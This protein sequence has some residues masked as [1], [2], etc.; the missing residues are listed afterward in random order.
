M[1][2]KSIGFIGGGRVVKIILN[3]LNRKN[4]L[5]E[6]IIV[7]DVNEDALNNL[8]KD[9]PTIRITTI[10]SEPASCDYVFV[11]LHPPV[12]AQVLEE[13]KTSFNKEAIL[14]SLAPK[15]SIE[16]ISSLLGGFNKIVRMIPNA[17]SFIN[18]GYNPVCYSSSL[19]ENDKEEL[20]KLFS[21]LGEYP[22]VDEYNLEGYAI[23]TAMGPTYLWFQLRKLFELGRTFGLS[24]EELKVGITSMVNGAVETYF[25]TE[26]SGDDVIDLVP[27]KPLKEFEDSINGYYEDSLT[28]LFKK[29]K[30]N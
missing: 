20:E 29:L 3:A 28:T 12:M 25:N 7:S 8:K 1:L 2:N 17:P 10:N 19:T 5:P 26:L 13:L 27:V 11:S 24:E 23:V 16:K 22:E 21:Q 30:T 4:S 18:K 6:E 14:I 9:F 15:L